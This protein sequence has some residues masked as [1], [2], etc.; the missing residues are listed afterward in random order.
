MKRTLLLLCALVL[1]GV[2]AA[3][4]ATPA[5]SAYPVAGKTYYLYA[6]QN[7]GAR[8]YLYNN[9]GTLTV[10]QGSCADTDAYKWTVTESDGA[11]VISNVAGKKLNVGNYLVLSDDGAS[12]NLGK[13]V[14]NE[15]FVSL[16]TNSKWWVTPSSG[17]TFPNNYYMSNYGTNGSY[18]ASYVFEDVDADAVK[19]GAATYLGTFYNNGGSAITSGFG[20][21]W[22]SKGPSAVTFKNSA[23]NNINAAN[24]Y[25]F[26]G[27]SG[28]T[29][30][31]SCQPAYRITG[32]TLT[33]TGQSTV[34]TPQTIT[35]TAGGSA[36]SWA[37]GQENTLTVSG[38]HVNSTSFTM[39]GTHIGLAVSSFVFN[40]EKV[41]AITDLSQL[42][43]SKSY[44][45]TG[46]RG[47]LKYAAADATSM[48]YDATSA[49]LTNENY[50]IAIIKSAKNNYYAY[51]VTTGKFIATNNTLSDTPTPVFITATGNANYPWFISL[52]SDKTADNVNISGGA[53]KFITYNSFDDGNRWAIIESAD[54]DVP[55]AATAAIN[56][57]EDTN[58]TVTYK[59]TYNG[60][61]IAEKAVT[62]EAGTAAAAPWDVPAFCSFSACDP[63]TVTAETSEVNLNMT[64]SLPFTISSS[65]ADATWYYMTIRNQYY[66]IYN[67]SSENK[68]STSSTTTKADAVAAAENALWAFTGDPINGF[69]VMNKAAGDG[70]YLNSNYT[71]LRMQAADTYSIWAIGQNSTGFTFNNGGYYI[72]DVNRALGYWNN[73]AASTDEGSTMR[74]EAVDYY[75]LAMAY[76]D[77]YASDNAVGDD[78]YFGVRT[79]SKAFYKSPIETAFS[80]N[81]AGLTA[82]VY[83]NEIKPGCSAM[84]VYPESGYYRIKSSGN[85]KGETY[86]TYG[87][88]NDKSKY[89]LVTTLVANKMT[90]AGTIF[91]LTSTETKGVYTLS[92]QGLN[93]Q[94]E[95]GYDT[96]FTA[97]EADGATFTFEFV[98]KGFATI[99]H[100]PSGTQTCFHESQWNSPAAVVRWEASS[101]QSHW[102]IEKATTL[103][104]TLNAGGDGNY[105]ATLC[106]PF[107]VTLDGCN[108]YT[109][110]LNSAKTGL[111]LSEAMTEV[112]AGT[113]VL[114]CGT[115]ATA[116]ANIAADAAYGAP[117]TNTSLT[118]LTGTYT[119]L[120]VADIDGLFLGKADGKVGFYR[121]NGTTLKANRA[122]LPA[123]ALEGTAGVK[124]FAI[125]F[126][127]ATAIEALQQQRMA[128]G[129]VF[130]LAGQRVSK[131]AKG[132]YVVNGKK[133]AIK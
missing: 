108:A 12:F 14:A 96:P 57:F 52:T 132:I 124:G 129:Q 60:N 116:T 67:P 56:A 121:W 102:S 109:L 86:I 49:D 2:N 26:P 76:I 118:S 98:S 48:T 17:T 65:Y 40:V 41:N 89:G 30:T 125:Q 16:H 5:S 115:S 55:A 82:S 15:A 117:L 32:Y 119:D 105:Y 83:E 3:W 112:P 104:L 69:K 73:A 99:S 90:D 123:S 24:A 54:Y 64:S 88:C 106:L 27:G 35:P 4:A 6:V 45:I 91:K 43:N 95:T 20:Q 79:A 23:G 39:S 33:A 75:D 78:E 110:T 126:D 19:Y 85:R 9:G 50:R 128:N 114:L 93:V 44:Y 74:I 28:S 84:I 97:T 34:T 62:Q 92:T 70:M 18:T 77:Q 58:V 11:Y 47:T 7:S 51:S 29:Y 107:T 66:V 81:H 13:D 94:D 111:T 68:T 42:S 59:L 21:T 120:P 133:V 130:N 10:S 1:L 101:V 72:N 36:T 71:P 113:P 87:Y 37:A 46:A 38:L 80:A 8:S 25:F 61:V 103:D 63:E 131:P 53:V 127:T 100:N 122:Y 31:I 22:V